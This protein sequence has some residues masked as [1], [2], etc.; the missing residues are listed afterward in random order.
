MFFAICLNCGLPYLPSAETN[1]PA[2]LCNSQR[3][4]GVASLLQILFSKSVTLLDVVLQENQHS[5]K[6]KTSK[7]DKMG[8]KQQT[9]LSAFMKAKQTV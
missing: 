9:I 6:K 4:Y 5:T 3:P 7:F 2:C 8:N 1:L